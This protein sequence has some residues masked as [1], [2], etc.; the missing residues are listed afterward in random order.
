MY[1]YAFAC[2]SV[3]VRECVRVC[4]FVCKYVRIDIYIHI[5]VKF[6]YTRIRLLHRPRDMED[7][8]ANHEARAQIR[9]VAAAVRAV[10]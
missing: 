1:V 4:T 2:V 5:Y 9:A 7:V 6:I 8:G 10:G 3:F